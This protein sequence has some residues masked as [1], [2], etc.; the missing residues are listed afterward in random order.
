M[1][2]SHDSTNGLSNPET[3]MSSLAE[4]HARPSA[5][6]ASG[7]DLQTQEAISHSPFW[8]WLT[9][10]SP[11]GFFGK[12]CQGSLVPLGEEISTASSLRWGSSGLGSRGVCWTH[13]SSEFPSD[14]VGSSLSHILERGNLPPRFYLSPKACAGILRRA[15]RRGKELP[16]A[17][18]EA[19]EAQAAKLP[20]E[21]MSSDS[22]E[23][24]TE[25]DDLTNNQE[26]E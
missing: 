24:E 6:P 9:K 21:E 10:S 22:S 1:A 8:L 25:A 12:T 5:W 17:L 23:E 20:P 16:P 3:S 7:K 14:A 4:P 18:K 26:Q 11:S 2:T 19:L 15:Q 13:N